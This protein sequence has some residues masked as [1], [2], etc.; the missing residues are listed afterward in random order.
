MAYRMLAFDYDETLADG[1]VIHADTTAALAA[2]KKAGWLLALVTG[3]PHDDLLKVCP[4]CNLCDLL[5]VDNG[6]VMRLASAGGPEELAP[7]PDPRLREELRRRK[8]P[9][10]AGTV[11]TIT[12]RSHERETVETIRDLGLEQDLDT[13]INRIAIMIVPHGTS[14]ASGFRTA[15]ARMGLE[16]GEVI[17][18]GDDRN[19]VEFLR[20]AGLRVAVANAIDDVKAEADLV[21]ALPS[22]AGVARFIHE[23]VL[24]SPHTLPPPHQP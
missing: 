7:R 18:F 11:A 9:F 22:G 13:F 12:R 19:D 8:V 21:T 5:V 17:A 24:A 2:A 3:R 14:K 20:V 15:L 4:P 6:G 16:P 1:G 10:L 23:R